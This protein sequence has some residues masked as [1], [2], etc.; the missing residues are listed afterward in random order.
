MLRNF[1]GQL[2]DCA[3]YK[4]RGKAHKVFAGSVCCRK[5]WKS[6]V[7]KC[8]GSMKKYNQLKKARII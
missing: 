8:Y 4:C 6:E 5:H 1:L 2:T 3:F 7:E